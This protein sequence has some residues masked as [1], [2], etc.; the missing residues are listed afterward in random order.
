MTDEQHFCKVCF[1]DR[2]MHLKEEGACLTDG[3]DCEI[4]RHGETR[5]TSSTGASKGTKEARYDLIPIPA[6]DALARLYGKGAAKYAEHN[7][8]LGYEWSKSYS[9]AQRHMAAFWSGENIDPETQVP[10]VINAAFHMFALATYI[11]EHPEFDD[12]FETNQGAP[13]PTFQE[14]VSKAFEHVAS[15]I[16]SV[17]PVV[18]PA[19]RESEMEQAA[20]WLAVQPEGQTVTFTENFSEEEVEKIFDRAQEL[21]GR[22]AHLIIPPS[23]AY[24]SSEKELHVPNV[25]GV[26]YYD[27]AS[28]DRV[29][30]VFPLM[31]PIEIYASP[32]PG[33]KF[34]D[35]ADSEWRFVV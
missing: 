11:T 4:Y 7:W 25:Q 8:R 34:P 13:E 28:H 20:Q 32:L 35:V 27:S 33:Y 18:Y 29:E 5:V 21:A 26:E 1:H 10:H 14:L 3:C 19:S 12:R 15:Q 2:R 9:A 17:P 31:G 16:A 22:T 30:G 23:P 24:D 6:L